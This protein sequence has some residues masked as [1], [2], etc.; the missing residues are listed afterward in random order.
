[1]QFRSTC[2]FSRMSIF[3]DINHIS[4]CVVFYI[5]KMLLR[6]VVHVNRIFMYPLITW[7]YIREYT[8]YSCTQI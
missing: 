5:T 1:M 4:G 2:T 8:L 3:R 6:I 7:F